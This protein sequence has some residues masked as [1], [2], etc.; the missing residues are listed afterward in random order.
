MTEYPLS[1]SRIDSAARRLDEIF[2]RTPPDCL[3]HYTDQKGI[4]GILTSGELWG[5]KIQYM[6]DST[7]WL[8]SIDHAKEIIEERLYSI[9][10]AKGRKLLQCIIDHLH[11]IANVNVCSVS[12]CVDPDLLSQWRG[13]SG[14]NTGF[15]IGFRSTPLSLIGNG[16]GGRLGH[17]IYKREEQREAIN[18]LI[19]FE[20]HNVAELDSL[21]E[22]DYLQFGAHF[23]RM[24]I[25]R[26]VFFKDIGFQQEEEWRLVTYITGYGDEKF[27]FRPGKSMLIPYYRIPLR[28]GGSWVVD[29]ASVT[30]GPCPHPH[31]AKAGVDGLLLKHAITDGITSIVQSSRIPYRSW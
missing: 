14:D 29:I 22:T 1:Q 7:E 23:E 19:D 26:G 11:G 15:A 3:F 27:S 24:L 5:T 20:L 4:L 10:D 17:C 25:Q 8:L 13:Y 21:Q 6:N 12:F 9:K 2:I 30:V 28:Q 18:I 16:Y 31:L